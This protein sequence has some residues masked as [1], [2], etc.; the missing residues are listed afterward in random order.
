MD[1]YNSESHN[2]I[3]L[4]LLMKCINEISSSAV[5]LCNNTCNINL[6]Q[7]AMNTINIFSSDALNKSKD[8]KKNELLKK[9][10][11]TIYQ[12]KDARWYTYLTEDDNPKKRRKIV[13]KSLKELE[14]YLITYY[15][16]QEKNEKYANISLR[17]FY[18]EWLDYKSESTK[19][20]NYL[21]RIDNDWNKFYL[22]NPIIDIPIIELTKLSLE[23]FVHRSIKNYD[24]TSKQ[25][26]NMSI[27]LKQ[28]LEYAKDLNLIYENPYTRI[29]IN[30]KLFRITKKADDITQVFQPDEEHELIKNAFY[31][32]DKNNSTASLAIVFCFYTGLRTSELCALKWNDLQDDYTHLHIQRSEVKNQTQNE[33]GT[34][35]FPERIIVEH[36]K[37]DSGNRIIY[38][39]QNARQI[40][41]SVKNYNLSNGLENSEFIFVKLNGERIT[42]TSFNTRLSRYCHNIN[43]PV[44]RMHKIRKTVISTLVD[45]HTININAIR[46]FSG[47]SSEKTLFKSYVYNRISETETETCIENSFEYKV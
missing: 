14:A 18:R 7:N 17:K 43:I 32:F 20:T 4:S 6:L 42:S 10:T 8:M 34:W 40:L 19:S 37:S 38:L 44:K 16:N 45:N 28:S 39:A 26:Y 11:Y 27:I 13:K 9:H 36:T 41:L 22:N 25:F 21:R 24:L 29:R 31:D 12:G 15:T 46:Q 47:H 3:K 30:K 23:S 35:N 2:E 1:K 33:D 5:V